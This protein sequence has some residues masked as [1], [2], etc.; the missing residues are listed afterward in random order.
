M[1]GISTV[2]SPVPDFR[3]R[4]WVT[5]RE[6]GIVGVLDTAT[7]AVRTV[8]L[9]TSEG[10]Y[11]SFA[12]TGTTAFIVTDRRLYRE[13]AGADRAEVDWCWYQ[14]QAERPDADGS[15]TA[16]DLG[17]GSTSPSSTTPGTGHVRLT[18]RTSRGMA[19]SAAS[20]SSRGKGASRTARR[21]R[22]RSSP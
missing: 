13:T 17:G 1:G 2:F 3:G 10:I 14:R 22:A 6:T 5:G 7:G 11:N 15:G 9:G 16:D 4:I 12:V 19:R 8:S 20:G 21:V 18:A